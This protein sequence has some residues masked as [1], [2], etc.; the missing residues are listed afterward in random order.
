M[1]AKRDLEARRV[2]GTS[3]GERKRK[4]EQ[5]FGGGGRG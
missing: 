5:G 1:G 2:G 4:K 3:Q